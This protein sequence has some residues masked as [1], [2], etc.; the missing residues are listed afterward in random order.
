MKISEATYSIAHSLTEL[1]IRSKAHWGYSPEQMEAWRADLTISEDYVAQNHVF[2]LKDQQQ[3]LGYY[4]FFEESSAVVKLDNLFIDPDFMG[5]GFG[6]KLMDDFI[7]KVEIMGF[8]KVTLD[9]DPNARTFYLK[10]GFRIAGRLE[11]SIPGR[12]LPVMRLDLKSAQ[13]TDW[14]IKNM[15][16]ETSVF[17]LQRSFSNKEL[18][19][20]KRGLVPHHMEDKWLIYF[21]NNKLYFH[22]SWSGTCIY[23]VSITQIADGAE[24]SHV[25]VN[26]NDDQYRFESRESEQ[27]RL[28]FIID[29]I[30][31]GKQVTHPSDQS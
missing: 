10:Y 9:A 18:I 13:K 17:K 21:E 29:R 2:A 22:R 4:S 6:G 30:L 16:K 20:L 1:T 8:E 24:I 12:Y 28:T 23:I 31:L 26:R 11:T 5:Q 27:Q 15:P 25:L 19:R 3:I 14:K 7:Q